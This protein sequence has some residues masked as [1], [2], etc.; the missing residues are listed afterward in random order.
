VTHPRR[1]RDELQ[2]I[3]GVGPALAA[4][5]RLLGLSRVA[6]LRGRDPEGLYAE[7][8]ALTGTHVDRCVLYV[9]RSAVYWAGTSSPDPELSLWWSWKDGGEAE[10]RGLIPQP[11]RAA[12]T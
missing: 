12:T 1:A 11:R 5:L 10:R 2:T 7:L 9:F 8:E 4:D 6:D 3:P